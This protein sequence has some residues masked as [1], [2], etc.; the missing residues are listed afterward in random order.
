MGFDPDV[1]RVLAAADCARFLPAPGWGDLSADA[2]LALALV[3]VGC[4][5][6]AEGVP[7]F[8]PAR[9]GSTGLLAGLGETERAGGYPA[10]G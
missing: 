1:A 4:C 10:A 3:K 9:F 7:C 2:S 6:G 5:P 8:C